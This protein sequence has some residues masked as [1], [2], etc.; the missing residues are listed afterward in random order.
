LG[1]IDT[2]QVKRATATFGFGLLILSAL[3]ITALMINALMIPQASG[4]GNGTAAVAASGYKVAVVRSGSLGAPRG[5]LQL[6][7]GSILVA[8]FGGWTKNEGRIVKLDGGPSGKLSI[9]FSKID[10][11]HGIVMG[12][13]NKVYVGESGRVFRFDPT[14][15][16]PTREYVIGG[17]GAKGAAAALPMRN[18]H[19][20]PL[21]QVL[22]LKD[23]SLLVNFGSNTNNCANESKSGKCTAAT[24][25][26]AVSVVRR[27]VFDK[28]GGQVKSW[29]A[30]A[31]GL[32]NSMALA[33]HTSGTVLQVENSRDAINEADAKLSDDRLPHD[34]LNEL[35]SGSNYG[36]PYCYDNQVNS[37]EFKKYACKSSTTP[38]T[39]LPAH[40]A[41][42]GMTYWNNQLVVSY[43]GYRDTGHRVVSFPIDA[44]GK[45]NGPSTEILGGWGETDDYA[46][47]GPVGVIGIKDGSLLVVD[48]RN[49]T[50]L[51]ITKN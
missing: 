32:R 33:Q 8:D 2:R 19:L 9:V 30:Y 31:T 10:R 40:C 45:P 15:A 37:P 5:L 23:G 4:A 35:K 14:A 3:T 47:G 29:S 20:H 49:D 51:Q 26:R 38:V 50:L 13:D 34:E 36:W 21:T 27:Y 48:D 42:L 1:V 22:F 17:T 41:P 28:T 24:G 6:G 16:K 18:E 44:N 11:P 43:H 25:P 46:P 12:P 39:L 7:D